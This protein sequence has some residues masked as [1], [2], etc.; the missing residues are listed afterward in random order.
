M[1][2][3]KSKLTQRSPLRRQKGVYQLLI[4]LARSAH[5]RIGKKGTFRF[6][7]GYYI[8][9]GSA[10]RGLKARLERH[11]R[12]EKKCFWHIDYLLD[13]ASVKKVFLFLDDRL[14]EC[15]LSR[16]MLKRSE[17]EVIVP[18]FGASDCNC[19]THLVFFGRL[20]DVPKNSTTY[21]FSF[22][23]G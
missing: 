6:P 4:Y 18:K 13:H 16:K 15:F 11:L 3:K 23:K 12:E 22:V 2:H 20:K 17:A 8:Y 1:N 7:K 9:T 21:S 5:I 14:D 19:P 10:K